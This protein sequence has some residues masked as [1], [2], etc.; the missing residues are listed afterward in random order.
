MCLSAS[1]LHDIAQAEPV[2]KGKRED[3]CCS[4]QTEADGPFLLFFVF[5][6]KLPGVFSVIDIIHF[7]PSRNDIL[8]RP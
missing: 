4:S 6:F 2:N 5:P 3:S 7:H 8:L 1:F